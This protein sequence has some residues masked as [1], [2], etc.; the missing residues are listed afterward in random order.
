MYISD[1]MNLAHNVCMNWPGALAPPPG[2]AAQNYSPRFEVFSEVLFW[3]GRS[4]RKATRQLSDWKLKY[5]L[6]S[7]DSMSR[8]WKTKVPKSNILHTLYMTPTY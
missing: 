5:R 1:V 8:S 7:T 6:S 3:L 2:H 4:W